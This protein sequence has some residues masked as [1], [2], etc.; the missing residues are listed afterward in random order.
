[1]NDKFLH[2]LHEEP[3]PEFT[4][5]LHQKLSQLTLTPEGTPK[6][7]FQKFAVTQKP[8]LALIAIV[9]VASLTLLLTV[10]PVRAFMTSL[11]AKISGQIFEITDDYPGDN[12]SG[13]VTV[14]EPQIL[15]L[16]DALAAFPHKVNL[17]T[18][19]PSGYTLDEENIRVYLGEDAGFLADTI[20]FTWLSNDKGITLGITNRD[21]SSGEIVAPNSIEEVSLDAN[22]P[23]VIIRGG[24]DADKKMWTNEYGTVRLRWLA[25]DLSYELSGA[26]LAQLTEMALSI[27]K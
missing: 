2:Q 21:L 27:L 6:M 25:G 18:Y 19:I 7:N 26:D 1:M 10:S 11:V 24:W 15:P 16:S 13:D 17:P 20:E 4:K 8:K 23:A 3:S 12:Y 14:V 22:H 9:L 5:K